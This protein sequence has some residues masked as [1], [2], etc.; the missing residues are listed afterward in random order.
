MKDEI[1]V[2]H[3]CGLTC[4]HTV[5]KSYQQTGKSSLAGR[6]LN[7]YGPRHVISNNVVKFCHE[8]TQTSLFSFLLNLETPNDVQSVAKESKKLQATCKG[9]DQTA[10]M[11]MLV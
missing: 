7:T 4:L 10:R 5:C 8:W 9:S 3:V 2:L 1:D 6:E 11:R